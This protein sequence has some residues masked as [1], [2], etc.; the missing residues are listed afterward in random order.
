M[1]ERFKVKLVML[2]SGD[3]A[4]NEI[5]IVGRTETGVA[6]REAIRLALRNGVGAELIKNPKL[7][8]G[9]FTQLWTSEIKEAVE[10]NV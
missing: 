2:K 7:L 3:P 4:I 10:G 6:S 8:V 9:S 5:S 1:S